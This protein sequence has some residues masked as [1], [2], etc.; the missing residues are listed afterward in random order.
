MN[1]FTHNRHG[2]VRIPWRLILFL[3]LTLLFVLVSVLVLGMVI[4]VVHGGGGG[5]EGGSGGGPGVSIETNAALNDLPPLITSIGYALIIGAVLL[6]SFIVARYFDRRPFASIG[7]G[8]HGKWLRELT[9]GLLMGA[10]FIAFIVFLQ[11]V[12]GVVEL[13]WTNLAGALLARGFF[14]YALLFICVG[15]F[16]EILFRGYLLQTLAEGLGRPTAAVLISIPFGILHFFNEGGTVTGAVATGLAGI[17][18]CIAY[19]RTMSLW[20]PIGMHIT[21][22][23][24]MSWIFGLPVSGE[25]MPNPPI[26]GIVEGPV[27]LSGGQFGPEA[28]ALCFIGMAV[29]GLIILRAPALAPSAKAIEWYPPPEERGRPAEATPVPAPAEGD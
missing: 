24:T 28:S 4:A 12:F 27:W 8:L 2:L 20:L 15:V 3:L 6:A 29:M 17:L 13:R 5:S 22:N 10:A 9:I 21:W 14:T 7:V 26:R 18:L 11:V 1:G 23:F 25:L 19:F 16:E